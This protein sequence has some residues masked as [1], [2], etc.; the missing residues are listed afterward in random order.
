MGPRRTTGAANYGS[1]D[2][3]LSALPHLGMAQKAAEPR[4]RD[5]LAS[6]R[7]QAV[8]ADDFFLLLDLA[9]QC[10]GIKLRM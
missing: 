10:K 9:R 6:G 7:E 4:P 8:V 1:E 2:R 5:R 3:L